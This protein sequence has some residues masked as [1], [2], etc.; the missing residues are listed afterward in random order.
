MQFMYKGIA[1][2]ALAILALPTWQDVQARELVLGKVA[3]SGQIVFGFTEDTPPFSFVDKSGK[4]AGYSLDLC[5]AVA[6][7][8]RRALKLE[9][10]DVEFLPVEPDDRMNALINGRVD[11][12]CSTT[13]QTLGRMEKVDFTLMTFVTG[14]SMVSLRDKGPREPT[15]IQGKSVAVIQGTTTQSVLEEFLHEQ[16]I[17]ANVVLVSNATAGMGLLEKGTV[18]GFFSDRAMLIGQIMLSSARDEL[19]LSEDM[20]SFEPY[21]LM[22]PRND[23]DF[24]LVANR[25]LAQV[26][27]G[28]Q[29]GILYRKWFGLVGAR[30]SSLL[31]ALFRLQALPD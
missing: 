31:M 8:V 16:G 13:T 7:Q 18:D 2:L 25:A 22:L 4:P 26:Y 17:S 9:R 11:M 1:G 5:K 27:H 14:A 12:D 23:A 21:A 15:Q 28:N 10:L 19:Q 29:I 3:R 20:I 30:P 6:E 24:R